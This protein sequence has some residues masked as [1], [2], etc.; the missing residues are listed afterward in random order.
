MRQKIQIIIVAVLLCAVFIPKKAS[1]QFFFFAEN[2]NVGKKAPDLDLEKLDGSKIVLSDLIKD[3]KAIIFFWATWC[4]HCRVQLAQIDE[5]ADEFSQQNIKVA[6]ISIGEDPQQ[7]ER[8]LNRLGIKSTVFLDVQDNATQ[9][10]ELIGVPTFV[11]VNSKGV[12][13]E[14]EHE[15]LKNYEDILN[16]ES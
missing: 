5:M 1:G 3:N 12:I 15:L 4:P 11:Y 9:V 2:P 13:I 6:I 16:K 8:F 14:V 7:V 10:F